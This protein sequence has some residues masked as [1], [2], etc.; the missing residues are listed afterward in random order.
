MPGR[1]GEAAA[2]AFHPHGRSPRSP[3]HASEPRRRRLGGR[4]QPGPNA[5]ARR[6]PGPGAG[7]TP[8]FPRPPLSSGHQ[9]NQAA[10]ALGTRGRWAA[11][12][13]PQGGQRSL[14]PVGTPLLGLPWLPQPGTAWGPGVRPSGGRTPASWSP[15][16]PFPPP[17]PCRGRRP[18]TEQATAER[19]ERAQPPATSPASQ[20]LPRPS[21]SPLVDSP[22]V[23]LLGTGEL[24]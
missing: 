5:G 24:G 20:P 23:V 17:R 12:P 19:R 14:P 2:P 18:P 1:Q 10:Q 8:G 22:G 21:C 7:T 4:A 9:D 16:E 6:G 11:S 15:W 3:L 13:R